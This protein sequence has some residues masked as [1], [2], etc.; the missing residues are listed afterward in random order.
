MMVGL[1]PDAIRQERA[2]GT[3]NRCGKRDHH[4]VGEGARQRDPLLHEEGRQPGDEAEDQ[5]VDDDE[6]DRADAPGA[7]AE[8]VRT[9]R[10][11][12]E[13]EGDFAAAGGSGRRRRRI[14]ARCSESSASAS[15]M[16]PLN[17]SQRGNSGMDLRIYQTTSAPMPAITNIG[18]Q[19]NGG[20]ISDPEKR[21]RPAGRRRRSGP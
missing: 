8:P 16:R 18:R 3:A 6:H 15:A 7:A 14:R 12:V 9:S 10:R 1:P 21:R 13:S 20:M 11:A 4:R 2:D 5:R 17:S 19:P